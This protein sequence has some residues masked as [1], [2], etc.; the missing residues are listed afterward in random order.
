MNSKTLRRHSNVR[1]P[2]VIANRDLYRHGICS[3]SCM[4]IAERQQTV[5][6]D[7]LAGELRRI[8]AAIKAALSKGTF[9]GLRRAREH[10]RSGQI[11][12]WLQ[13]LGVDVAPLLSQ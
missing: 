3:I 10:I 11:I 5:T 4:D 1:Q 13:A 8:V 9:V 12:E 7:E 6:N 2:T